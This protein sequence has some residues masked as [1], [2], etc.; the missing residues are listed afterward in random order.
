MKTIVVLSNH[1]VWTY[2]LRA[3][4]LQELIRLGH[5][6]IVVV[7]SG[8]RIEDL[9]QL[10]CEHMDVPFNRH[11]MN[12]FNEIR[13]F[14]AYRK[15]VKEV[16]PDVVLTYT[17]KPN[18]YGAF[19]CR[20]YHIPCIANITGL[21]TAVEYP[22]PMQS[23]LCAAY[24]F[25]FQDIY[26]VFFQNTANRDVFLE[27]GIV[28]DHYDL[29]PGSGVNV[30]RFK[31]I[32]YPS[33]KTVEFVFISRIMKEKGI[34][35]YLSAARV[36]REKYPFTKFHVCGFCEPEYSGTLE[37]SQKLGDVIYHGMVDDVRDILAITH[38]LVLPTYYPEGMSNVLLESAACGRP[39]ITTNRPGCREIIDDGYNGFICKAKN[40]ADLISVIER[41]INLTYEEKVQMGLNGRR[42]VEKQFD[43]EIV[44]RKYVAAI[45]NSQDE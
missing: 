22:G 1:S 29:L 19:L 32:E 23:V 36:I 28:K 10:G 16:R 3:E 34:D 38:C 18:L 41:F 33:E 5:R 26:K 17:V 37:Q 25:A 6:V 15:I 4:I 9:K 40:D 44:V 8:K 20:K 27:K 7:G 14:N 43:R 11:G 24:R 12:P 13:L 2:N 45:N 39:I 35:Q 21:G 42:K 31:T 30:N